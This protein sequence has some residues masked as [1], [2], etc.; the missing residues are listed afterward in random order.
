[1]GR[2]EKSVPAAPSPPSVLGAGGMRGRTRSCSPSR[3][4]GPL[5]HS[6]F[7][8]GNVHQSRLVAMLNWIAGSHPQSLIGEG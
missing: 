3:D 5:Q 6:V 8:G 2:P 4:L 1:M 7:L